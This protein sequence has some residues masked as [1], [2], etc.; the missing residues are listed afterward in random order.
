MTIIII[1]AVNW[2]KRVLGEEHR[3]KKIAQ[4]QG[5]VISE[6]ENKRLDRIE[7]VSE[8]EWTTLLSDDERNVQIIFL[9][10]RLHF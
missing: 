8:G 3:Q 2:V 10:L 9:N 7:K 5:K 1:S 6:L 4:V